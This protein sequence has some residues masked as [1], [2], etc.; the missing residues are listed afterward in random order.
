MNLSA[1]ETYYD[2]KRP[3]FL[4]G[5]TIFDYDFD[6]KNLFYSRRIG[7][8][9]SLSINPGGDYYVDAP[10]MTTILGAAKFSGTTSKGLSVGLIQSITSNEFSRVSDPERNIEKVKVEPL[11]NYTVAR[12]KKGYKEGN[13]VVGGMFTSTNRLID[14]DNLGFLVR[15]AFTGGLDLRHHW[16]DKEYYVEARLL[17]SYL[18]GSDIAIASLQRSSAR[19][20][21]RPGADYLN[22]DPDRTSLGGY[23]GKIKVG[24][25]SKGLWK[26]ASDLAWVSPG[27][28]LNDIGYMSQ[29]DEIRQENELEYF[30]NKPMAIFNTFSIELEQFNAWNFNGSYLGSGGHVSFSSQFR[31]NYSFNVNLIFQSGGLD[32]RKLRGG[33]DML[34]PNSLTTFGNLRTDESKKVILGV[35]YSYEASGNKA[36]RSF[37]FR[38]SIA[39]R[40]F[41]MLKLSANAD[42]SVNEDK[43][44]YVTAINYLNEERYLL[45]TID[46]K[47]FGLTFRADLNIS[48]EFAIQ[49]YGSPFISRGKYSAMKRITSPKDKDFNQRFSLLNVVA[50]DESNVSLDENNDSLTDYSIINPDFNFHEFRSN[51]V[52]KWEY[53]PGSYIYLVWSS[54]RSGYN[55]MSDVSFGESVGYLGDAFP[56]NIFMIKLN[57]WF[58]L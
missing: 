8:S 11:T 38:P 4:E 46:Q 2:E 7:H 54:D 10:D 18:E 19:Y 1:F 29:A 47:T 36:A 31:N 48:P 57:Y 9:P 44:Q 42:Y 50:S 21:Q 25:G 20:Y 49:Y 16:N 12:I 26:Y 5:L 14:E 34:M 30:I 58:S 33:P 55:K 51:L 23:G 6:D 13:T 35:S 43:L 15:D 27:L 3:F 22:Y 32:T 39:V 28:E 53:N 17:G 37:G 52:A 56:N 41:G 24:K 45:G 40:P